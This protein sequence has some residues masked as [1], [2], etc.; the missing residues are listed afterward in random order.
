MRSRPPVMVSRRLFLD[1]PM[2]GVLPSMKVT[3]PVGVPAPGALGRTTA[4]NVTGWPAADGLTVV[5][6]VVVVPAVVLG[7]TV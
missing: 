7:V 4:L 6:S 3:V 5:N 2:S 1:D